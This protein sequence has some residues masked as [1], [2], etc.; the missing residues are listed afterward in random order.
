MQQ[1]NAIL[2]HFQFLGYN[3]LQALD[4][5]VRVDVD[6]EVAAGCRA[7]IEVNHHIVASYRSRSSSRVHSSSVGNCC[8]TVAAA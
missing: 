6:T 5:N 2:G 7:N 3:L 1:T 4:T 8:G